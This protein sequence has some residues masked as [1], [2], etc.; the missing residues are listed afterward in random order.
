[1]FRGWWLFLGCFFF[2]FVP[3]IVVCF[4]KV[5]W[6]LHF[7]SPVLFVSIERFGC[8]GLKRRVE[9]KERCSCALRL[10]C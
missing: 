4:V 8:D 2:I 3:F 6:L 9:V 1:M 5:R 10:R 7:C